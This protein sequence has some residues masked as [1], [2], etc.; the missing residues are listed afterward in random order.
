MRFI[1]F[2][3]VLEHG[4]DQRYLKRYHVKEE[5][6]SMRRDSKNASIQYDF[7]NE[8]KKNYQYIYL[9]SIYYLHI[10]SYQ[11]HVSKNKCIHP[12][13]TAAYP[14]H[15]YLTLTHPACRTAHHKHRAAA[16]AR[17]HG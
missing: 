9:D 10:F 7:V 16:A 15:P 14:T 11:Y 6:E 13:A 12:D 8:F 17:D 5:I 2:I 1:I 3:T 4:I